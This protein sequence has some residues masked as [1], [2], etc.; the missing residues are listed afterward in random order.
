MPGLI[1]ILIW[2]TINSQSVIPYKPEVSFGPDSVGDMQST[3][4]K[5][6]DLIAH[7]KRRLGEYFS[8]A[9]HREK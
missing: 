3:R 6:L 5:Q 7:G 9:G 1:S 4:F 2:A 8:S